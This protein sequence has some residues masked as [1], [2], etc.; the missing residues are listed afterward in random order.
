LKPLKIKDVIPVVAAQL[1]ISAD[2]VD[3]VTAFYWAEVRHALT[4]MKYVRVHLTNLGDFTTKHWLLDKYIQK[5]QFINDRLQNRESKTV[6][7][8]QVNEKL[9]LLRQMREVYDIEMQRK[10]FIKQYKKLNNESSQQLDQDMEEQG[11]DP[12]GS[13]Q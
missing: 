9:G 12:G 11:S 4:N 1:N 3:A 8:N 6:M 7:A 10:D 5:Y 2:T 13:D